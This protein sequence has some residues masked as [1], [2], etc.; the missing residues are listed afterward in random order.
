MS[1]T[2]FKKIHR[3]AEMSAYIVE[4]SDNEGRKQ[5][6]LVFAA[7]DSPPVFILRDKLGL[8]NMVSKA[9]KWFSDQF[10]KAI[11]EEESKGDAESV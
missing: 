9:S 7:K 4:Y 1:E 8:E 2:E 5:A 3:I 6:R 10:F 11:K